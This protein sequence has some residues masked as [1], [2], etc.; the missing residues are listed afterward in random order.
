MATVKLEI[1]AGGNTYTNTKTVS[2]ADLTRFI[3]AYKASVGLNGASDAVAAQTWSQGVLDQMKAITK[4]YE[5]ARDAKIAMDAVA[6]IG[7]T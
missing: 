1:V 6:D 4:T 2:G 3:T 5:Q 7:L